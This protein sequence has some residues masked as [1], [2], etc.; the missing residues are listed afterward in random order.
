MSETGKDS[1]NFTDIVQDSPQPENVGR[2][3]A[4]HLNSLKS[5]GV[6]VLPS[7]TGKY[8]FSELLGKS[9]SDSEQASS[10]QAKVPPASVEPSPVSP[11]AQQPIL[12][13]CS[14]ADTAMYE[15]RPYGSPV[16]SVERS[17]ELQV[18]QNKVADCTACSELCKTR[19]QTV[20]G[21]GN[22]NARL[23]FLGE[24]PGA[25]ED[26]LGEPFV[27]A[28]GQLLDK[29]IAAMKLSREEVYILNTLKCRPPGNRNPKDSELMNCSQFA[30]RQLEIIQPD[31]ICCLGSIAAKTL[32]STKQSIGRMRGQFVPWRGSRVICTYHP[33]YLLRTPSAKKLVWD[34]MKLLMQEMGLN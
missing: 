26:R 16:S 33:A 8:K 10:Q 29:I 4:Q 13:Q 12:Q 9:L 31:F 21:V 5:A 22:P 23:V 18:I 2:A 17:G 14:I 27:G 32:L 19:T 24:A 11:V 15:N 7:S 30:E 3:I 34:D 20:F 25:D 1:E 6:S 28:A